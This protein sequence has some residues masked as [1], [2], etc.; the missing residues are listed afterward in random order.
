MAKQKNKRSKK[1]KP[2]SEWERMEMR[3]AFQERQK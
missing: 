3:I 2:L 1:I